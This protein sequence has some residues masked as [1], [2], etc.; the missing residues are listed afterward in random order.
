MSQNPTS[1]S[2]TEHAFFPTATKGGVGIV[3][4]LWSLK[5]VGSRLQ[6]ASQIH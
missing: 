6:I 4:K 1:S 5:A 3:E 2:M